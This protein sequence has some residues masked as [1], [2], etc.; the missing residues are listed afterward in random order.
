MT[1]KG[2]VN[3]IVGLVLSGVVSVVP[4]NLLLY[5]A[6]RQLFSPHNA[7]LWLALLFLLAIGC[8]ASLLLLLRTI[9]WA[10]CVWA[11]TVLSALVSL[12]YLGLMRREDSFRRYPDPDAYDQT[13]PTASVTGVLLLVL[14][15]LVIGFM[16]L[17]LS[18]LIRWIRAR[19]R[20][21]GIG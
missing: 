8:A 4:V 18:A 15:W 14:L 2:A 10:Y 6:N 19:K 7:W 17:A 16:P 9:H 21:S 5:E 1:R 3:L 11:Q 12:F 20:V 13:A